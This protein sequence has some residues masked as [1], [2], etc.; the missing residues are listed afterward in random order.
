MKKFY[1]FILVLVIGCSFA[2]VK[3]FKKSDEEKIEARFEQFEKSYSNGDRDGCIKCFDTKSRN[4]IKGIETLGSMI[5]IDSGIFNF[6]LGSETQDALFGLGVAKGTEKIEFSIK[7]I[8]FDTNDKATLSVELLTYSDENDK[9]S[10]G[11]ETVTMVREKNE[12]YLFWKNDWYIV[13][14]SL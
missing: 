13:G 2:Y 12:W 4:K 8:K 9:D 7:S 10:Q 5:N 3:F 11:E 14:D 6:D 1:I